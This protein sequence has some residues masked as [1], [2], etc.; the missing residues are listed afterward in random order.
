MS[1]VELATI[2]PTQNIVTSTIEILNWVLMVHQLK[3]DT[4]S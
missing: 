1:M 4:I 3:T 2:T